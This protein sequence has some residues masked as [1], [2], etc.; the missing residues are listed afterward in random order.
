MKSQDE[1]CLGQVLAF[2]ANWPG[3]RDQLTYFRLSSTA[4]K[5]SESVSLCQ[6]GSSGQSAT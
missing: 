6:S 3:G 4:S 2:Q 1:L 5:M